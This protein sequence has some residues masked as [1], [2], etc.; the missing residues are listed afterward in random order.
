MAIIS[1]LLSIPILFATIDANS[2]N[3]ISNYDR[4]NLIDLN[5]SCDQSCGQVNITSSLFFHPF[6][7][8]S[9][10][11]IL[12]VQASF[13]SGSFLC[14]SSLS[15]EK[16]DSNAYLLSGSLELAVNRSQLMET[17]YGP[18]C[19]YLD[20]LPKSD[21]TTYSYS[22]S[23]FTNYGLGF[24]DST[25]SSLG[26]Q[27]DGSG[28]IGL[29]I[30]NNRS[31]NGRIAWGS[32]TTESY[33]RLD[34]YLNSAAF[35]P[36][37]NKNY[38]SALYTFSSKLG[39][40]TKTYT[41]DACYFFEIEKYYSSNVPIDLFVKAKGVFKKD[42]IWSWVRYQKELSTSLSNFKTYYVNI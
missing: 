16:Y 17:E 6:S 3:N 34:P 4:Q 13:S 21:Q 12:R 29:S 18:S 25:S 33:S 9:Y 22:F 41:I 11:G 24:T 26:L 42:S 1:G 2:I 7:E 31:F 36:D 8:K 20:Y 5:E 10:I 35:Q 38:H 32:S 23:S 14:N 15:K 19:Y 28:S 39:D 27:Y 30:G 37:S 40:Q